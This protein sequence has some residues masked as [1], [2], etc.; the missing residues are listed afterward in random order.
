MTKAEAVSSK[1]FPWNQTVDLRNMFSAVDIHVVWVNYNDLTTTSLESLVKKG[2][3][4]EMALV[5]VSEIL[6]FT[7]ML[8]HYEANPSHM[9]GQAL[10]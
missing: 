4:P 8:C 2:N 7:Q 1:D 6:K 3:H 5:Q 9:I 10:K